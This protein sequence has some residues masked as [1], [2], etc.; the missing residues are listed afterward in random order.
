MT[1]ESL[2]DKRP[3]T[4]NHRSSEGDFVRLPDGRI[5]F[6]Y[7]MYRAGSKDHSPCDIG[8]LFSEDNG[9]TFS[10]T[11]V[12]LISA[13]EHQ[14]ENIMSVSMM[15]M[16]NGDVGIFYIVRHPEG[17]NDYVLRRT[18]DGKNFSAPV[19]CI[20]ERSSYS[21]Y[22]INNGRV[23]RKRDGRL[24][25]P[26]AIHRNPKANLHGFD[27]RASAVFFYSDDDGKTWC[28]A[29]DIV[30]PPHASHS[31][32]G[33]QEPGII[34][35]PSGALY[36][37]F[38]TDL[39]RQYES[40]SLDNLETFSVAQPS[41]FT[42]AASPLSIQKNP[43]SEEYFAVWNPVPHYNG[44]NEAPMT[45]GRT[46]LVY[47]RSTDGIHFSEPVTLEDDETRGFCYPSIFFPDKNTMLISYCYG[48]EKEGCPLN[49]M[50]IIS[51]NILPFGV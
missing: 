36:A 7:S 23:L 12:V 40:V 31:R 2:F 10:Q 22:V 4:E 50:K 20:P 18:R 17:T 44:R 39:G 45:W 6:A 30:F 9:K 11:P 48:G 51:V 15:T 14:V 16:Q 13:A 26:A 47:A 8:G 42:S 21:Y 25:I 38:R 49:S 37:W 19:S 43:F 27:G 35:L 34:E 32:T 24:I 33:L 46:P 1:F 3:T 41:V 28:E 5:L 29:P